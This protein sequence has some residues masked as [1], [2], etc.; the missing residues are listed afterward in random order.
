MPPEKRPILSG[1]RYGA[2]WE[3]DTRRGGGR[4]YHLS[5]A[6]GELEREIDA[7]MEL[8]KRGVRL[9][10]VLR[11]LGSTEGERLVP[12]LGRKGPITLADFVEGPLAEARKSRG[13]WPS[14]LE[15]IKNF[16]R[17]SEMGPIELHRLDIDKVKSILKAWNDGVNSDN[18][19]AKNIGAIRLIFAEA[20][21]QKYLRRVPDGLPS[22]PTIPAPRKSALTAE[23][24]ADIWAAADDKVRAHIAFGYYAGLCH[25]EI[26]NIR[27]AKID[28]GADWLE[29]DGIVKQRQPRTLWLH[30]GLR[31]WVEELLSKSPADPLFRP[32]WTYE[33]RGG[34]IHAFGCVVKK[35][36]LGGR[37]VTFYSLRHTFRGALEDL[38]IND[39]T[40]EYL[41]GHKVPGGRGAYDFA[42][43][44]RS[45][46]AIEKLPAIAEKCPK[47]SG[48]EEGVEGVEPKVLKFSE[49]ERPQR[50]SNPYSSL[51]RAVS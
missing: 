8:W 15:R 14:D 48:P 40:I 50:E 25:K 42:S 23:M 6:G 37:G 2:R 38:S 44:P 9:Q 13:G 33:S 31:P 5:F 24:L 26:T 20:E 19:R 41:M 22:R 4:R 29:I 18:S 16:L 7:A 10:D 11:E 34:L 47:I 27:C 45:R 17:R 12:T 32:P 35:A 39:R 49:L 30:E 3:I 36:G 46:M 1:R 51:E 21:E 43:R 28:P